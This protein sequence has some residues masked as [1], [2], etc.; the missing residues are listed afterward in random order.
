MVPHTIMQH[1]IMQHA[2][3]TY[4]AGFVG[5]S[6]ASLPCPNAGVPMMVIRGVAAVD[7]LG[8]GILKGHTELTQQ[9][10]LI[11]HKRFV[12]EA[13][14]ITVFVV[15]SHQ[16]GVRSCKHRV[17]AQCF[18]RW[19]CVGYPSTIRLHRGHRR[20]RRTKS[21]RTGVTVGAA[22]AQGTS[23]SRLETKKQKT[24]LAA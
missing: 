21:G 19:L 10:V 7:R 2:P 4:L 24:L 15:R 23:F 3:R 13:R 12:S 9:P 16:L 11:G 5:R 14:L 22:K 8:P 17:G 18:K 6:L 20:L 1:T